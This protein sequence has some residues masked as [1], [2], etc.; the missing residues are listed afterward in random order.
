M[1]H[2]SI[3]QN[4][5]VI[6]ET[7]ECCCFKLQSGGRAVSQVVIHHQTGPELL[8]GRVVSPDKSWSGSINF[9]DRFSYFTPQLLGC[10]HWPDGTVR[11]EG[12]FKIYTKFSPQF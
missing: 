1:F 3:G 8:Q 2:Y 6:T 5:P 7:S 9:S 4:E 10:L 11:G 12:S